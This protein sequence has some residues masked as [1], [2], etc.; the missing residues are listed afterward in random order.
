MKLLR[1]IAVGT[2]VF[3]FLLLAACTPAR[4]SDGSEGSG[5]PVSSDADDTHRN[6]WDRGGR[7]LP[8]LTVD[9]NEADRAVTQVVRDRTDDPLE[10]EGAR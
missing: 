1:E 5:H 8:P 2:L 4:R 3:P 9:T 10:V 7:M 6:E